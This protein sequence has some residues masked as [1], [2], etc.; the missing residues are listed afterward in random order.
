M[1]KKCDFVSFVLLVALFV[2]FAF[3]ATVYFVKSPGKR[4]VFRF[5][6]VDDG[7]TAIESRFLPAKKGEERIALY[8]DEL[9][10]GAKTERSRPIFS[11]GTKAKLCF[12]RDKTL[13]I[14]LTSELLYQ[15][16]NAGDIMESIELFKRNIFKNFHSV[17]K[18]ELFIDGKNI[19]QKI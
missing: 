13:Y 8:V 11:P 18:I 6:S 3:S 16:G 2:A 5:E 10:L 17:K 9:L 15:D 19:L 14:D 12:L 7:K 1:E 4:Y